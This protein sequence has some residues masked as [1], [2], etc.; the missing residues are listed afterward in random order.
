MRVTGGDLRG[1]QIIVPQKAVRPTCDRVRE[2][3][4]SSLADF[5][6][7]ARVLDIFAGSGALGLEAFSRGAAFVCW[8]E[9]DRT[10][11]S[12]LKKNVRQLCEPAGRNS[13][14]ACRKSSV[15]RTRIV[16]DDA[17]RFLRRAAPGSPFDI[18]FADPPYDR[19]GA[20]LKKLLR[21]LSDGFMLNHGG[22]FI[23]EQNAKTPVRIG[24]G[25]SLLK[26]RT[27]GETQICV[28]QKP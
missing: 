23:M 18:V 3:L 22:F 17:M 6:S 9:W 16:Q 28:L 27:Y 14:A 21:V 15:P 2:A 19:N 11:L 7:G 12:V 10:V 1:R 26:T 25:W 5:V 13:D 24:E 20:W 4:F 8:V